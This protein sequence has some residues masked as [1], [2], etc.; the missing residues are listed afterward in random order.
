[1]HSPLP[2]PRVTTLAGVACLVAALE[3]LAHII[4]DRLLWLA[5]PLGVFV[6][7]ASAIW[8]MTRFPSAKDT[9]RLQTECHDLSRAIVRFLTD[10]KL[11]D[12]AAASQWHRLPRD[13]VASDRERAFQARTEQILREW[14]RTM[15]IYDRDFRAYALR[16]AVDAGVSRGERRWFEQPANPRGIREVAQILGYVGRHNGAHGPDAGVTESA[17][18]AQPA[19]L[20]SRSAATQRAPRWSPTAAQTL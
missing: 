1:M 2:Y 14:Q 9:V 11:A 20:P 18:A 5:L 7:V 12:S 10:R 4:S 3:Y 17:H 19:A 16:L 15:A 13:A 8:V 6:L